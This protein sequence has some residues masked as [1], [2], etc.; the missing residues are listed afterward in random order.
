MSVMWTSTFH[1]LCFLQVWC[2]VV[3][4][5]SSHCVLLRFGLQDTL[6]YKVLK[7]VQHST[8]NLSLVLVVNNNSQ[9]L[10]LAFTQTALI[11]PVS[12]IDSKSHI[13]ARPKCGKVCASRVGLYNNQP[14]CRKWPSTFPKSSS[15]RNKPSSSQEHTV[16]LQSLRLISPGNNSQCCLNHTYSTNNSSCE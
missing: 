4:A 11:L 2:P 5:L 13:F 15:A 10:I 16:H 6:S 1:R 3:F 9:A 12:H 14:A 7:N 8:H